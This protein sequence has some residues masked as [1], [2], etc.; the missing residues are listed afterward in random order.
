VLPGA[1]A[2]ESDYFPSY[3]V[4]ARDTTGAG[5]TL[6]GALAAGL[7]AGRGLRESISRAMA[8]AALAVTRDGA[9]TAMPTVAE[10]DAFLRTAGS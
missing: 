6:T 2:G 8:A 3:R 10:I 4:E 5:D 9:R 7:A 1:S